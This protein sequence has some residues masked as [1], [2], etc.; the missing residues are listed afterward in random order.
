MQELFYSDR[1]FD[2]AAERRTDF[3]WLDSKLADPKTRVLPVW[4]KKSLGKDGRAVILHYTQVLG[5]VQHEGWT[6][7]PIF[8]GVLKD[9]EAQEAVF[10]LD[11][12]GA[13]TER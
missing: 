6:P 7:V 1:E 2:R 5:D 12:M 8:L 3:E 9:G 4:D 13:R 10:A 11:V